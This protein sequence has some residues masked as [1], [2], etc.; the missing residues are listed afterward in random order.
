M[1]AALRLTLPVVVLGALYCAIAL[2]PAMLSGCGASARETTIKT[3]L[4]VVNAAR[5]GFVA[6]DRD[7]QAK[8]VAEAKT[9]DEGKAALAL[10]RDK[11]QAILTAFETTY[12]ALAVAAI[13]K[14]DPKALDAM[15]AAAKELRLIIEA[16]R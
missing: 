10:Y 15:L 13:L 11:R 6:I 7:K 16:L 14:D 2:A 1:R 4:T 5:D 9:L 12:R 3:T 8:I